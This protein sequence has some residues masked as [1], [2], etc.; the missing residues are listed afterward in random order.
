M[1]IINSELFTI[2]VPDKG[3]KIVNKT[4][5]NYH[6]KVYLGKLDSI[7][8]Y[9]EVVDDKYVN[10]DYVVELNDLKE[11]YETT[12]KENKSDIEL[13]M[14]VVDQMYTMFEPL[15]AMIPR[16]MDLRSF[17]NPDDIFVDFYVCLI[18]KKLKSIDDIPERFRERV[19]IS[20][21]EK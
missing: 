14:M 16:T 20:L 5:G 3:Y 6:T 21:M 10:M 8:N 13:L 1:Q 9:G 4:N 2:L 11:S 12:D 18:N 19:E 15:L 7:D 17:S